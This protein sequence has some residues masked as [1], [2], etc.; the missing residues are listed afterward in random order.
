M[1][2]HQHKTSSIFKHIAKGRNANNTFAKSL[3]SSLFSKTSLLTFLIFQF[4]TS[5]AQIQPPPTPTT[6]GFQPVRIDYNTPNNNKIPIQPTPKI[7]QQEQQKKANQQKELDL[8]KHELTRSNNHA[9]QKPILIDTNK[10]NGYKIVFENALAQLKTIAS[11]PNP[12]LADAFYITENAFGKPYLS[13]AEYE[14]IINKSASF[15]QKWMKENNYNPNDNE[16]KHQAIQKFM[17]EKLTVTNSTGNK[18]FGINIK[19]SQHIPFYYDYVDYSAEQDH[20]NFFVTKALATGG[21]QCN[22]LPMVYL[23]I[24]EKLNAPTF[25]TFAPQHSFIKYT[26]NNGEIENYEPTSNWHINDLWYQE[27]SFISPQAITSGLYL[28][29]L[30][31]Q[32]IVANCILDLAIQ[33]IRKMPIDNGEFLKACLLEAHTCFPK[34]NNITSCSIYNSYL[35]GMLIRYISS[36]NITDLNKLKDD[37]YAKSIQEE[38][39]KNEDHIKEL[40]YQEM[41][42]DMYEK[43][44]KEHEFKSKVQKSYKITGKQKRNLFIETK[45]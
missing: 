18:E 7:Y 35:K 44:L 22:S 19:T 43:M 33:Y 28:D 21:G 10:Y 13:K 37:E 26:K 4:I 36:H 2:H 30:S 34:D 6:T 3:K 1:T 31:K 42:E 8:I 32:K 40:G 25:L 9:K 27:N 20:R 41:P 45:N 5:T 12:S 29:T 24:A 17:S 14:N 39:Q 23:L 38:Y 15:I 16:A 11:N